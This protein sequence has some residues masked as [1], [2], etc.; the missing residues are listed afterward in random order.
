MPE[1]S[2]TQ[3]LRMSTKCRCVRRPCV[4]RNSHFG[5]PKG[6][7]RLRLDRKSRE[8]ADMIVDLKSK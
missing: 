7:G 2:P 1:A 5:N 6:E 8:I 4:S 3:K